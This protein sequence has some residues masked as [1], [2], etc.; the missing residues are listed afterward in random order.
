MAETAQRKP[1]APNH[2]FHILLVEDNLSDAHLLASVLGS[3]D[4]EFKITTL[5]DGEEAVQFLLKKNTYGSA[6]TPGAVILDINLPKKNG[7]EILEEVRD[8]VKEKK[9]PV[10]VL[11]GCLSTNDSK[12]VKALGVLDTFTKPCGIDELDGFAEK[13]KVL[14]RNLKK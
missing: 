4:S 7:F 14:L 9:I 10:F 1:G 3:F 11:S 12:R 5:H 13:L 8:T 6:P 2:P